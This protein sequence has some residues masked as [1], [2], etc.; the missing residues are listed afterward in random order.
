MDPFNGIPWPR[1]KKSKFYYLR[2]RWLHRGPSS[3]NNKK[4]IVS[5]THLFFLV[6]RQN[7]LSIQGREH[8]SW[9]QNQG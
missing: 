8:Q 5:G 1:N 6:F 2:S 9:A 4:N 3:F 7:S